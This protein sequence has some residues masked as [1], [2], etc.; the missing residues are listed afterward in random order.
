MVTLDLVPL[1]VV[2]VSIP[3]L[4]IFAAKAWGAQVATLAAVL[5]VGLKVLSSDNKSNSKEAFTFVVHTMQCISGLV[6][7]SS[8]QFFEVNV[9]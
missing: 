1:A 6:P 3:T 9:C 8:S 4:P 7:C 5:P 2:L